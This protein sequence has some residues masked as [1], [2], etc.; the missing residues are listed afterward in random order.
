MNCQITISMA[1]CVMLAGA[2]FADYSDD[3]Y[4]GTVSVDVI[5]NY[6]SGWGGE[7]T[8]YNNTTLSTSAYGVSTSGQGALGNSFQSFCLEIKEDVATPEHGLLGSVGTAAIKGGVVGGSDPI[9]PEVAWLYT[10]FATGTLTGYVYTPGSGRETSAGAL[11]RVIWSLEGE[12]G[13]TDWDVID[14]W[15]VDLTDGYQK[16]ID[17]STGVYLNA[18]QVAL[19]ATWKTEYDDSGWS[20]IGDAR[21]LNLQRWT[22]TAWEDAQSQL[23]LTAVPVPGAVLLGTLGLVYAGMKLRRRCD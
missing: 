1:L 14:E 20:G 9:G 21:V 23:Y 15:G 2:V 4:V 16:G 18:A 17:V 22:G 19:I 3:Y 10:Q 12:G 5:D 13:G 7:Y 11:Q 8:I 6:F